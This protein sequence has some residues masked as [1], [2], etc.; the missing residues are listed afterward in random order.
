RFVLMM[1]FLLRWRNQMALPTA[2]RAAPEKFVVRASQYAFT[3]DFEVGKDD[4]LVEDLV[5]LRDAVFETLQLP[6]NSKLIRLV[7]F[8]SHESYAAFLDVNHPD[9]PKR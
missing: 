3:T 7:I 4:A 2:G 8:D 1:A 9:L 5:G 6:S